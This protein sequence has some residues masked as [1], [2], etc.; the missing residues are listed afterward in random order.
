M[1]PDARGD[2]GPGDSTAHVH[3]RARDLIAHVN[4]APVLPQGPPTSCRV[5]RPRPVPPAQR[6]CRGATA[7]AA[8]A[9]RSDPTS[10]N[11]VFAAPRASSSP[12]CGRRRRC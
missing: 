9:A 10:V 8:R 5:E 12:R 1:A 11:A 6:R 7:S 2:E 4:S 3:G